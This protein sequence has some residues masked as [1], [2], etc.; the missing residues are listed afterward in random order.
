[1]NSDLWVVI[2]VSVCVF[3]FGVLVALFF[4]VR[5]RLQREAKRKRFLDMHYAHMANG[6]GPL[7]QMG[8]GAY[9]MGKGMPPGMMGKGMPPGMIGKGM[10]PF[11]M[12]KGMPPGMGK[13]MPPGMGKGMP[14]GMG[15]G[16]SPGMMGKG[17]GAYM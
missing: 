4:C 6:G 14:P 3:V 12:G 8:K 7:R 5:A 17:Y 11:M 2:T 16:M 1:M 10:P 15:K 13:G 9:M